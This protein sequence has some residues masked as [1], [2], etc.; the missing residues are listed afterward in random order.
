[1]ILKIEKGAFPMERA[2]KIHI[3]GLR[4][5]GYHGVNDYEKRK[6]QP[7]EL[8]VT[9]YLPLERPC[10]SDRVED[11]ISYSDACKTILRVMG[12]AKYDLLERVA[13]RVIKQLFVEYPALCA[14]NVLLK[15]PRAPIGADF[16][17]VA[18]E[19]YRERGDCCG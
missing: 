11:T 9:L 7:F 13:Y 2:D 3:R 8:D 14:V 19:L 5:Y 12:E 15:K 4:A 18:V 17:D 16:Q 6:G 1:M 10:H